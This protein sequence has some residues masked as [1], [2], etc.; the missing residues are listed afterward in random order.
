MQHR[1]MDHGHLKLETSLSE[2][3]IYPYIQD[4]MT[5]VQKKKN[6]VQI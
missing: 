1:K 2:I 5:S 4:W 6:L 3:M